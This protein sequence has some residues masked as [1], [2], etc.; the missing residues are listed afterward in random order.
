M[1]DA[2]AQ[3]PTIWRRGSLK[4]TRNADELDLDRLS[5]RSDNTIAMSTRIH[6]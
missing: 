4:G 1:D 5:V 3:R 2:I 6:E